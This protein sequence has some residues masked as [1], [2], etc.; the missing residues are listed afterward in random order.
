MAD[1]CA[2]CEV[3]PGVGVARVVSERAKKVRRMQDE[4]GS[5]EAMESNEDELRESEVK[6]N[7]MAQNHCDYTTQ[8]IS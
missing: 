2:D 6:R 5:R 8:T 7:V 3:V 4:V 1:A